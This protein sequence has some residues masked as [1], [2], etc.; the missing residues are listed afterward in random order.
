[1]LFYIKNNNLGVIM[2]FTFK[3]YL[4]EM[5]IK[6]WLL[7]AIT[8]LVLVFMYFKKISGSFIVILLVFYLIIDFYLNY[9]SL[10]L[11]IKKYTIDELK[12]LEHE[13]NDSIFQY[14]NWFMTEK[15]IFNIDKQVF[16]KYDEIVSIKYGM[17]I[18]LLSNNNQFKYKAVIKLK[19]NKIYKFESFFLD[20]KYCKRFVEIIKHRNPS[21]IIKKWC[22]L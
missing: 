17:C 21:V 5:I 8:I 10:K 18:K 16:I 7:I 3:R 9:R 20:E 4:K 19:N 13:L 22:S 15:Y 2:N 6:K 11:F 12:K 1:M 14:D